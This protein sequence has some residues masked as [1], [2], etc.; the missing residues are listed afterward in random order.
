V[1]TAIPRD[2]PQGALHRSD[3]PGIARFDSDQEVGRE[4][5]ALQRVGAEA[6]EVPLVKWLVLLQIE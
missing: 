2:M 5:V 1:A 3:I 6:V 4:G